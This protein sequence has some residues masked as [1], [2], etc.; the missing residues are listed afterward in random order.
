MIHFLVFFSAQT[1]L[2]SMKTL[3]I[4]HYKS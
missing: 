1:H 3:L 4:I 2:N